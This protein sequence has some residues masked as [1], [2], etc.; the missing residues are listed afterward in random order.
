VALFGV[1]IINTVNH[2]IFT[3]LRKSNCLLLSEKNHSQKFSLIIKKIFNYTKNYIV[4]MLSNIMKC[5]QT[6]VIV[7]NFITFWIIKPFR[8][9]FITIHSK[10][11]KIKFEHKIFESNTTFRMI[12]INVIFLL[13][14]N[15]LQI[16]IGQSTIVDIILS[17][18]LLRTPTM[19]G[20]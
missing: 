1:L 8:L 6:T 12:N 20:I 15:C 5:T 14:S 11:Y 3:Y 16:N 19:S 18:R 17:Q 7:H 4:K 10:T 2:S 13:N 9:T